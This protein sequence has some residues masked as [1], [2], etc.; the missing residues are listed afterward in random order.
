VSFFKKN[1]P[2]IKKAPIAE[3]PDQ[4]S[5]EEEIAKMDQERHLDM[6][7]EELTAQLNMKPDTPTELEST[8]PEPPHVTQ[9]DT[10]EFL[11]GS[12][13]SF[14]IPTFTATLADKTKNIDVIFR[15]RSQLLGR[16]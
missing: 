4:T 12:L 14:T 2:K 11:T 8:V 9:E 13:Q 6:Q 5:L 1:K 10:P 3:K 7:L 16:Q 15:S